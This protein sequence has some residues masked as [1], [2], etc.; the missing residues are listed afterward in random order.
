ML[1]CL[2]GSVDPIISRCAL[3]FYI[4]FYIISRVEVNECNDTQAHGGRPAVAALH[5]K[6]PLIVIPGASNRD[7]VSDIVDHLVASLKHEKSKT[8]VRVELNGPH[9]DF[10]AATRLYYDTRVKARLRAAID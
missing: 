8:H 1:A 4:R 10:G 6:K 7:E 9:G 3:I 5:W 2:D